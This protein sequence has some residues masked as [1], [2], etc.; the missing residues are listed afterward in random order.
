MMGKFV[1]GAVV[2]AF[3]ATVAGCEWGITPVAVPEPVAPNIDGATAHYAAV[4]DDIVAAITAE[5]PDL[6]FVPRDKMYGSTC[7]RPDGTTGKVDTLPILRGNRAV[8]GDEFDRVV[9]V[10]R[11]EAARAG[12]FQEE[13][14]TAS[15][16]TEVRRF[17]ADGS[18]V[19]FAVFGKA[20]INMSIGCY[21]F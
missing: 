1:R 9:E 15:F 7:T 18:H 19:L 4:Q 8:V 16:G 3:C 11:A 2:V 20:L 6:T 21:P 14:F 17:A 5:F 10:F 13:I 12:F